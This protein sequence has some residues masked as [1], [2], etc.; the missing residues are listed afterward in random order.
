MEGEGPELICAVGPDG[1]FTAEASDYQGRW[2]KEADRDI[3]RNLRPRDPLSSGAV[4]PRLS[5]LLARRQRST[6][7]VSAGKLVHS[8]NEVPRSHV[9]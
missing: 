7:S 5:F 6:H 1:K 9:G 4:P 2:V 3:T 8:N